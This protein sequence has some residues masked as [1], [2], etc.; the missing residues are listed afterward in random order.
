MRFWHRWVAPH[1]ALLE[2][3]LLWL[4]GDTA[5]WDVHYAF[6]TRNSG[7]VEGT[8]LGAE[9]VHLFTPDDV[10]SAND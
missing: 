7:Q 10:T 5:R 8:D 3:G 6:F 1:G 2:K 4:R 9:N